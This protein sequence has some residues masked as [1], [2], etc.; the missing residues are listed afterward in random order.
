MESLFITG[1]VIGFVQLVKS[2]FDKDYRSAV[3]IAGSAVI[4]GIVGYFGVDN[5]S[6]PTG[7]LYGLAASGTITTAKYLGGNK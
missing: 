2:L 5:L 4:G 7:I 6:I 3:I 1:A